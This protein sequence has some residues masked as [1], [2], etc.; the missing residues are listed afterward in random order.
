MITGLIQEE[1]INIVNTYTPT[2]EVR[3][4]TCKA[5]A[6]SNKSGKSNTIVLEGLNNTTLVPIERPSRQKINKET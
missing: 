2:Q 5:N 3:S 6:E 1:D 4:S